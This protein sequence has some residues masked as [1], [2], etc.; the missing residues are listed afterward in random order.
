MLTLLVQMENHGSV[1]KPDIQFT[2]YVRG[3]KGM[4][5]TNKSADEA[6]AEL[7]CFN[8]GLRPSLMRSILMSQIEG[9]CIA[10]LNHWTNDVFGYGLTAR[11]ALGAL[12]RTNQELFGIKINLIRHRP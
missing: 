6:I 4:C 10:F 11:E 9:G 2:V 12:I 7:F 1:R 8:P 5:I 3:G